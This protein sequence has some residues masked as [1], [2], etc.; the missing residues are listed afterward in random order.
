MVK[1]IRVDGVKVVLIEPPK[2]RQEFKALLNW[3]EY[4]NRTGLREMKGKAA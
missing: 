1:H 2:T 4:K 3:C